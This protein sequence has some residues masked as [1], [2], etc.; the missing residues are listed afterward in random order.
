LQEEEG[1]PVASASP[2]GHPGDGAGTRPAR[3]VECADAR[4]IP[5]RENE[6]VEF[7]QLAGDAATTADLA[8]AA[9]FCLL[10]YLLGSVSTAILVCRALGYPDPR[11]EGSHNPGATNVLR[12]AGKPAAL[13]TLAGDVLKGVVPVV[14]AQLSGIEGALLAW[15]GF[16]AFLGHLYPLFFRFEGGK[17]VATA[18]GVINVLS[19]PAGLAT[20]VTWLL[21][22][23]PFRVS[24]LAA[25]ASWALAPL[26]LGYFAPAYLVPMILV[27]AL[28]IWRHR[29]NLRDLAAGR[30]RSFRRADGEPRAGDDH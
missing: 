7:S 22:F 10:G 21:V 30:E 11:S 13:L 2:R 14:L 12:I 18:L 17:G 15:I 27:S 24:S 4:R 9:A 6:R 25:V 5:G 29:Q 8:L 1:G 20:M 16:C 19:W 26:Y 3:Q 28:L 23:L